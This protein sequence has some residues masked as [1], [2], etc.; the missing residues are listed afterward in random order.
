[1]NYEKYL[2][3]Q[4]CKNPTSPLTQIINKCLKLLNTSKLQV[5]FIFDTLYRVIKTFFVK[6]IAQSH[7]HLHKDLLTDTTESGSC[8]SFL[9]ILLDWTLMQPSNK[10]L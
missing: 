7:R 2:H 4:E 10:T 8:V 1:M 9:N 6:Q 3:H 5:S